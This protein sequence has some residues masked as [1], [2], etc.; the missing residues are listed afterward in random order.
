MDHSNLI[1]PDDVSDKPFIFVSYSRQDMQE[2]QSILRI[3]K[4]N[5]FR[6][7]YDMGIADWRGWDR[8]SVLG[9]TKKNRS[10]SCCQM[11]FD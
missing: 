8:T 11:R 10:I 3:L 1:Q 2:V 7:W 4:K 6:F 9:R 5:Q